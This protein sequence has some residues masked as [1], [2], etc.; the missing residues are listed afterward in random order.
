MQLIS[1]GTIYRGKY[2]WEKSLPQITKVS[3][4]PLI[5]GRGI[6]TNNLRN[7]IF[8]D[9]KNQDLNVKLANLEFDCCY[10][11]ITRVK[12]I[13][14]KN[15]HDSVIAA[16]GGKVLDAGKYLAD[17]LVTDPELVQEQDVTS[18]QINRG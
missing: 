6:L 8:L 12:N 16:G 5:L 1:P 7:K 11:D 17:C 15:N 18:C 4:S 10:E 13:I 3:K 14:Y 9:L 2:A